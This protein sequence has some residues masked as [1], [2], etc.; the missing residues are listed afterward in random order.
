[1]RNATRLLVLATL[2]AVTV[3]CGDVVRQ[4]SSPMYLV[5][6][7]LTPSGK[8]APQP[9]LS[10]VV[11]PTTSDN[12]D[13]VLSTTPKDFTVAPT[14]NNDVTINSYHVEY[15]RTD[16]HNTQ[17]VDVPSAFDGALT[18]IIKAGGG[19]PLT[20]TF[21]LVRS[22][23]KQEAPLVQLG[24]SSNT[25]TT[26]AHVTFFGVDRTGNA[27]SVTGQIQIDFGK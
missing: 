11:A 24:T 22:V 2:I 25:L 10:H 18:G 19:N 1:M 17:G 9:V 6:S 16:G 5:I 21:T 15:T 4:G 23:A 20:L 14:S 8:T 7:S 13:V 27:V 12:G 26:A 3:S